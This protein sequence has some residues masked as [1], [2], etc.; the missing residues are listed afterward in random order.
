MVEGTRADAGPKVLGGSKTWKKNAPHC[1][2]SAATC[3]ILSGK[4]K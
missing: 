1:S 3:R 4:A 2:K